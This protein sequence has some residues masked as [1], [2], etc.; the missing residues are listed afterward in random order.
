MRSTIRLS[1]AGLGAAAVLACGSTVTAAAA[2]E[3]APVSANT[4][5]ITNAIPASH[6]GVSRER[7]IRIARHWVHGGKLVDVHRDWV[8]GLRAW[9]VGLL[10]HHT[11]YGVFVSIKWGKVVKVIRHRHW[12]RHE[13]HEHV[14]PPIIRKTHVIH[15]HKNYYNSYY[16]DYYDDYHFTDIE[17]YL[18]AAGWEDH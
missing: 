13:H 8:R 12:Q 4:T 14:R 10:K 5:A 1:L 16:A 15:V 11:W 18:A 7:A 3:P 17:D 2:A 6:G 9:K